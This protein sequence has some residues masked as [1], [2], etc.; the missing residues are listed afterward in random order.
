MNIAN[1][2]K[3]ATFVIAVLVLLVSGASQTVAREQGSRILT[4]GDS[5]LA[6]HSFSGRA[7]SNAVEN[8]LGEQVTD[9]SVAGARI[10]YGLPI[11]G[12]MGM[13]IAKQ[14]RRGEWDWIILNGGGNDLW[15]G[16]GCRKCDRKMNRL[17]SGNGSYGDIPR[18]VSKLRRTGARVIYVGYL[19]SPGIGSPIESCRDE[20]DELERRIDEMAKADTGVF[21]LSLAKLVPFGDRSFHGF[22][23]IHPSLKA[24]REIGKQIAEI[25]KR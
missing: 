8:A 7:V 18:L 16:C 10:I 4:M 21:F 19:R 12:A 3:Q 9:R 6:A 24:S 5:L 1:P 2:Y 17:I 25:I 13:K 20:G 14:Y 11:S 23:M 22:D 15:F